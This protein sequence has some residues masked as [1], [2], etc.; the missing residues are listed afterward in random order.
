MDKD[1][2]LMDIGCGDGKFLASAARTCRCR[3]IGIDVLESCLKECRKSAKRWEVQHLVEAIDQDFMD[4]EGLWRV[5]SRATVIYCFL[6]PHLIREI[7]PVL[8]RAVSE[9]KRVVL[10]SYDCSIGDSHSTRQPGRNYTTKPGNAL[11]DLVPSQQA[12]FGR[13]RCYG[14]RLATAAT[15]ELHCAE[16]PSAAAP[17]VMVA[18]PVTRTVL[19]TTMLTTSKAVCHRPQ[20]LV[21]P[22][23][24]CPLELSVV[25]QLAPVFASP[26]PQ[27]SA[28]TSSVIARTAPRPP[29][30]TPTPRQPC[31][32]QMPHPPL[33]EAEA[34][35]KAEAAVAVPYISSAGGAEPVGVVAA[36][37]L[38]L[39]KECEDVVEVVDGCRLIRS[40]ES[41]TG[42]L[43]VMRQGSRFSATYK[44]VYLGCFG[45]AVEAAV[46]RAKHV[47]AITPAPIAPSGMVTSRLPLLLPL[48]QLPLAVQASSHGPHGPPPP[49]VSASLERALHELPSHGP[50][51]LPLQLA[52]CLPLPAPQVAP[53]SILPKPMTCLQPLELP[54]PPSAPTMPTVSS[55]PR[56]LVRVGSKSR[57]GL[58]PSSITPIALPTF[59]PADKS[60]LAELLPAALLA[61]PGFLP[62]ERLMRL[63]PTTTAISSSLERARRRSQRNRSL[64][65]LNRLA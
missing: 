62:Q 29:L 5:V 59:E 49:P 9:G 38:S 56:L 63:R 32:P 21:D 50:P 53:K 46:A 42:Y 31:A 26:R 34:E 6:L 64:R 36:P 27:T 20:A 55:Y 25:P 44:R 65:R 4:S 52:A 54:V 41:C 13:L 43:G 16:P 18:P 48:P 17:V 12:W 1:D 10:L 7:E 60:L 51:G 35:T 40:G 23:A 14:R 61:E 8:L 39:H 33:A 22:T 19:P 47:Q 11:G 2:V 58:L 37:R 30:A 57:L 45:S 15:L 28:P 24:P 3:C